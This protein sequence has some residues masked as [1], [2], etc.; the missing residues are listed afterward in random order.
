MEQVFVLPGLG[1]LAVGSAGSHDLPV[2]EGAVLYFAV[3]VVVVNLLIDLAYGWLDPRTG[4][5]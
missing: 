2:I 1:G 4:N 5:R 3:I